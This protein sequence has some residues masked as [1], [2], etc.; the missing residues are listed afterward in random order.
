M[1]ENGKPMLIKRPHHATT[2]S[3]WNNPDAVRACAVGA[4]PLCDG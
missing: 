1:G 2:P 3:T 4:E